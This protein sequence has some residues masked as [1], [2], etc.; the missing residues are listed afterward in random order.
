[1]F[2]NPPP[3]TTVKEWRFRKEIPSTVAPH[4]LTSS[5]EFFHSLKVIGNEVI[6]SVSPITFSLPRRLLLLLLPPLLGHADRL[7]VNWLT[8]NCEMHFSRYSTLGG[9]VTS[10]M[11][12]A[13]ELLGIK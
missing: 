2:S 3:S 1:M 12:A 11:V 5:C 8:I 13:I 10:F 9:T 6:K 7:A 4:L